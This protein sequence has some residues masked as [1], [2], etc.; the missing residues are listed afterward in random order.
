MRLVISKDGLKRIVNNFSP[1]RLTSK[2]YATKTNRYR[3]LGRYGKWCNEWEAGHVLH[4]LDNLYDQ[5]GEDRYRASVLLRRTAKQGSKFIE[6][7]KR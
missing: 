7:L 6:A 2:I 4:V 5:Y 3:R 1:K